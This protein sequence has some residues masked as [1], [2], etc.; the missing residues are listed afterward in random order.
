LLYPDAVCPTGKVYAELSRHLTKGSEPCYFV[1]Q[2]GGGLDLSQ[3][4]GGMR[5]R[6][7][8]PAL[9]VSGKLRAAWDVTANEAGVLR[10][11][12]SGSGSTIMFLVGSSSEAEALAGSLHNRGM[13]Q[14]FS[15]H[16]LPRGTTWG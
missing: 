10:R 2:A 6:L 14:A 13:G 9:A 15:V 16:S 8:Q 11:M 3:L 7:E 5:N 4:A 12:V 1:H